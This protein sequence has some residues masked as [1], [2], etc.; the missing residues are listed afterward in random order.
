MYAG[1]PPFE[2]AMPNDPYYKLIKEKKYDT[3]WKAHSRRRPV[4]F[5]S[6]KF[7]DLFSKMVAF[8]PAERPKI[9]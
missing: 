2:K 1:N 7:Q 9:E 3:F 6:D 8:N 5:F 4:G